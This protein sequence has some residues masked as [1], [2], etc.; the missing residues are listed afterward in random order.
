M[1]H[2]KQFLLNEG[3]ISKDIL[4]SI[5]SLDRWG[6]FELYIKCITPDTEEGIAIQKEMI[7]CF[8]Q[9]KGEWDVGT[10]LY[11]EDELENIQNG[12]YV[13]DQNDMELIINIWQSVID[14]ADVDNNFGNVEIHSNDA[15]K[16][17]EEY[18][19]DSNDSFIAELEP[20]EFLEEV[21]IRIDPEIEKLINSGSIKNA[22]GMGIIVDY[23]LLLPIIFK[24]YPPIEKKFRLEGVDVERMNKLTKASRILIR[25]K[26]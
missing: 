4:N 5:I 9:G 16:F 8:S 22:V 2:L 13:Q 3:K 17:G 14:N 21:I 12:T 18:M 20:L 11:R 19:Y 1:K 26:N 6:A 7:S 24:L 10:D 25:G 23:D 15:E